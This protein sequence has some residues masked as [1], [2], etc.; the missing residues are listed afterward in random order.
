MGDIDVVG[1]IIKVVATFGLL[2]VTLRVVGRLNGVRPRPSGGKG[3]RAQRPVELVGRSS[4]GRSASVAVV[5]L[6]ERCF[7]LGVTEQ[8]INL[9]AEVEIDLSDPEPAGTLAPETR[10]SWRDLVEN[11]RERTVRH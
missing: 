8:H 4:L 10:P 3:G 11:L 2:F 7:A 6:G 1:S 5:R 9:I